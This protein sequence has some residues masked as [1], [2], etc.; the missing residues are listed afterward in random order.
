MHDRPKA[1]AK[2]K[3]L[4]VYRSYRDLFSSA[5]IR[6]MSRTASTMRGLGY[7]DLATAIG[8]MDFRTVPAEDPEDPPFARTGARCW[9][10]RSLTSADGCDSCRSIP[11]GTTWTR[12]AIRR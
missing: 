1:D 2:T 5:P 7:D 10:I 4:E 12:W 9:E 11:W 3:R 8:D 6:L